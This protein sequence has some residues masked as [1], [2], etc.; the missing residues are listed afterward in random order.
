MET[1]IQGD[2]EYKT[3]LQ[4]QIIKARTYVLNSLNSLTP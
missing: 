1:R 2:K 4:G 3:I